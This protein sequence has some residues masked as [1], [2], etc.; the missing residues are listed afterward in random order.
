[1]PLFSILMPVFNTEE[2]L[3]DAISSV[4]CQTFG[5]FELVIVDDGSTD[6]SGAIADVFASRDQRIVSIHTENKGVSS[7][8]NIAIERSKGELVIFLDGDDYLEPNA[9]ETIQ[10]IQRKSGADYL[11]FGFS[12]INS[13]GTA[14]KN[15][16]RLT[17]GSFDSSAAISTLAILMASE[18][19]PG[20]VWTAMFKRQNLSSLRFDR[21]LI[22]REDLVFTLR[23]LSCCSC[24]VVIND[25]LYNY[26]SNANSISSKAKSPEKA[27]LIFWSMLRSGVAI[28]RSINLF[29]LI[30]EEAVNEVRYR[31]AYVML[32]Q[33]VSLAAFTR[34]A[35]GAFVS[36][37]RDANSSGD[38][39]CLISG[40]HGY[41]PWLVRLLFGHPQI[42]WTVL[43]AASLPL[44]LARMFKRAFVNLR[45][46]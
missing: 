8:R 2:F 35:F 1:M 30:L 24:A 25:C 26:R 33:T 36:I 13:N 44:Q 15:S 5:D 4:L 11:R 45:A 43:R 37:L 16:T 3:S 31:Q 32:M 6:N 42:S 27:T 39:A 22:F 21:T 41:V 38:M 18:V 14:V 7:A 10:Q 29:P 40:L 12:R 17:Q 46:K 20:F 19:V 34:I 23:Y 28:V 9:L